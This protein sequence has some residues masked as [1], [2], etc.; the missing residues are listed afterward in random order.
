MTLQRKKIPPPTQTARPRS[1]RQRLRKLPK[2]MPILKQLI[3]K[4]QTK[5]TKATSRR[6]I[7][8]NPLNSQLPR[9][10]TGWRR[11]PGTKPRR[12]SIG[13]R[14]IGR[15]R[16]TANQKTRSEY[17]PIRC[18]SHDKEAEKRH[19]GIPEPPTKKNKLA[20]PEKGKQRQP[21]SE[22]TSGCL[23]AR[24]GAPGSEADATPRTLE[25]Q[26]SSE[27]SGNK[28]E[29]TSNGEEDTPHNTMGTA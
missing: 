26:I 29:E 17:A 24:I 22:S 4:E 5:R 12:I 15:R 2:T 11:R 25:V 14:Q 6:Q 13:S 10:R 8:N 1:T 3:K 18:S 16:R 9:E 27:V 23:V 21:V 19:G 20:P 7:Q 28:S